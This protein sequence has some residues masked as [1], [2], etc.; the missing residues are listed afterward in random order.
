MKSQNGN[1]Y[2][3]LCLLICGLCFSTGCTS[4]NTPEKSTLPTTVVPTTTVIPTVI[5]SLVPSAEPSLVAINT[6]DLKVDGFGLS[7]GGYGPE[8]KGHEIKPG[9][10]LRIT[11]EGHLQKIGPSGE[12][13]EDYGVPETSPPDPTL[14]NH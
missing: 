9:E 13:L 11:K 6:S 7:P 5:E 4:S 14:S 10:I 12:V 2:L 1:F 8:S 3:V